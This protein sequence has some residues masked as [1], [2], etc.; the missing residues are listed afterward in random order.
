MKPT[1]KIFLEERFSGGTFL[2][3]Q[4]I[5]LSFAEYGFIQP[6]QQRAQAGVNA[7]TRFMDAVIRLLRKK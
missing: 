5:D 3:T 1:E 2:V 7:K 6:I 4:V